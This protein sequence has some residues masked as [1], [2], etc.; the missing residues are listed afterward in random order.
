[1]QLDNSAQI[2]TLLSQLPSTIDNEDDLLHMASEIGTY[3]SPSVVERYRK[4]HLAY[5]MAENGSIIN[6]ELASNLPK[7]VLRTI[8]TFSLSFLCISQIIIIIV[9]PSA[10]KQ[11]AYTSVYISN[12]LLGMG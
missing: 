8:F 4:Q 5:L 3:L 9:L 6:P 11:E 1:M 12:Q 10:T 7:Q 2:L